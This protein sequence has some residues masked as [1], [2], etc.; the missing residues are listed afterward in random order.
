ML[1][2]AEFGHVNGRHEL[3]ASCC[4]AAVSSEEEKEEDQHEGRL[5]HG[6]LL[7]LDELREL[8]RD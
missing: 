5:P 7:L 6:P 2:V 4:Q 8:H 1:S 3:H